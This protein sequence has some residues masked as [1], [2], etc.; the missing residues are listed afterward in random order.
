ME[1]KRRRRTL[2]IL[3]GAWIYSLIAWAYIVIDSFL[4]P[5]YQYLPIS[6]YIPIP[7]NVLA[8]LAFPVSFVCFVY[9]EYLRKSDS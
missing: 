1:A 6:K 7:E 5:P 9:W 4:F 2:A 8:D 3:L